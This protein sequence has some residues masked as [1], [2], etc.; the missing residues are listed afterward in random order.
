VAYSG[1]SEQRLASSINYKGATA[2]LDSENVKGPKDMGNNGPSRLIGTITGRGDSG[3]GISRRGL[4]GQTQD[5]NTTSGLNGSMGGSGYT[6]GPKW[7]RAMEPGELK[8]GTAAQAHNTTRMTPGGDKTSA[9]MKVT[10]T[11]P[12]A[13][14]GGKY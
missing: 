7:K 6:A 2:T 3:R 14:R 13:L 12:K 4:I 5:R 8:P 10:G 11:M 9:T 1:K